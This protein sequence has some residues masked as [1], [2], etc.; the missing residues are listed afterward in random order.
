MSDISQIRRKIRTHLYA[1]YGVERPS[2][3]VLDTL[4]ADFISRRGGWS[5][6]LRDVCS[7]WSDEAWSALGD[8]LSISS[9]FN[10]SEARS[11]LNQIVR[12]I[13]RSPTDVPAGEIGKAVA[14]LPMEHE[15]LVL[16][17][18]CI[19]PNTPRHEHQAE[20]LRRGFWEVGIEL[21]SNEFDPH[22]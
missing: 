3:L 5:E 1:R 11:F 15:W 14:V 20:L 16:V 4:T 10:Y 13:V 12:L 19:A 17:E 8:R 9:G 22:G 6:R 18:W 7:E 21:V 2:D